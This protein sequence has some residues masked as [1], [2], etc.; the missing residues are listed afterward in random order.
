ME[1][2]PGVSDVYWEKLRQYLDPSDPDRTATLEN[3]MIKAWDKAIEIFKLRIETRFIKPINL[4]LKIH[5]YHKNSFENESNPETRASINLERIRPGFAT[6]ALDFIILETIQGFRQGKRNHD[7]E[8]K[9]LIKAALVRNKEFSVKSYDVAEDIYK[10]YRCQ[11]THKG[12]TDG[13][14]TISDKGSNLFENNDGEKMLNR[15]KFHEAVCDSF[16]RYCRELKYQDKSRLRKNFIN[17]M[18]SICGIKE[19]GEVV[20]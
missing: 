7:H 9:D 1:I 14:V 13:K 8:S 20:G 12:Q 19:K 15:T 5:E 16:Y 17:K 2:A 4:L 3:V 18:D 6:L 11:V 10:E